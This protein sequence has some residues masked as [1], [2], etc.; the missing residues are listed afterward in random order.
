MSKYK[1]IFYKEY[2]K[3]QVFDDIYLFKVDINISDLEFSDREVAEA[4]WVTIDE[5]EQLYKQ[6]RL[7]YYDE[8]NRTDYDK[9]IKLLFGKE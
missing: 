5:Y 4:K 9:C 2:R 1:G 7:L 6:E 3:K 8:F